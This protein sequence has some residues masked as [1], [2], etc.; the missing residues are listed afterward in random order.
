MAEYDIGYM[1]E[2]CIDVYFKYYGKAFHVLTYGTIIPLL[3]NDVDRNRELQHQ[4][5][6]DIDQGMNALTV[7]IE[8]NYVSAVIS[9]SRQ[10]SGDLALY[11]GLQPV[12]ETVVQLFKPVAE[13]GFYSYDC[14]KEL[15]DGKGLYRLVAYPIGNTHPRVYNDLPDFFNINVV[16]RDEERGLIT[17]F[18]M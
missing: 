6:I 5:S 8:Q 1:R 13:L 11:A 17:T 15:G 10:A 9:D 18:E 14:I 3:L 7:Q 16:D 12:E 2:H 4:V